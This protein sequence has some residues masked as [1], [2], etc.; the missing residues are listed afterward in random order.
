MFILILTKGK[1][2]D[3]NKKE[4][5]LD[6][7]KNSIRNALGSP[8]SY[9]KS[10]TQYSKGSN[11][12]TITSNS[13]NMSSS[14][15]IT[16]GSFTSKDFEFK[17]IT[18]L[19][20]N[21]VFDIILDNSALNKGDVAK[22]EAYEG[23]IDKIHLTEESGVL[24]VRCDNGNFNKVKITIKAR[25]INDIKNSGTGDLTG[26]FTGETLKVK[27][28]GT[29]DFQLE[30]TVSSLDIKNSGTGDV[31]LNYLEAKKVEF[32]NS[33]TGDMTL[34]ATQQIT[35]RNTG[36][37]DINFCGVN[38]SS[39]KNSGIGDVRYRGTKMR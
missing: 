6:K 35:G 2:L 39:I 18:A 30:G 32:T 12:F 21:T 22:V 15:P 38:S 9:E 14:D 26:K 27:N 23:Q 3:N 20:N 28:S 29:G 31:E 16:K 33:G 7:L 19:D 37:G 1:K 25:F 17:N 4:G 5:F 11:S 8:E 36:T 10:Y 24:M 34:N 13:I